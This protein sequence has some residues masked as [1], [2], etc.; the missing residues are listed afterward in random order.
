MSTDVL[1]LDL[2][3]IARLVPGYDPFATAPA[4]C[5]F[6][7]DAAE[8]AIAFFP[9]HLRHYEGLVAGEPFNLEPWQ[10]AIVA[11]IHGW[12]RRNRNGRVIRRYRECLILVARKSGKSPLAAGL[13]LHGLFCDP[14]RGQQNFLAGATKEQAGLTLFRHCKGMIEQAPELE[15][16][17][18]VFGGSAPSGQSQSIVRE[19]LGSF[20]KIV[21]GDASLGKHGKN[22][23]LVIID[24]LHEFSSR[25]LV[26]SFR[27]AMVSANKPQPLIIYT[28][29]SDFARESICNEITDYA[30]KVRDGIVD[31]PSFLPVLYMADH[32]DDWTDPAT[33]CLAGDT[34]LYARIAR[35]VTVTTIADIAK[36]PQSSQVELWDGRRWV[37]V[38]GASHTNG[39]AE[40]RIK[41]QLRSGQRISCTA[42]HEWPTQRGKLRADS[43]KVGDVIRCVQLPE[44]TSHQPQFPGNVGW[45]IGLYLAEGSKSGGTLQFS[46]HK[47]ETNERLRRLSQIAALYGGTAHAH[48][49]RRHNHNGAT[50]NVESSVL[51]AVLDFYVGG[52]IAHDKYLK[53]TVWRRD[54]AFLREV[55]KGYLE[56]D[57]GYDKHNK[58]WRLGFCRND[59]LADSIRTLAARLGAVLTLKTAF[60]VSFGE[61]HPMYR[62]EWREKP[63]EYGNGLNKGEILSVSKSS[64]RS[65]YHI[66]VDNKDGL[67][68]LASGVLTHNS[69][70][71]PNMGV[72]VSEEDLARECKIAQ[73]IPTKENEF[74][75]LHLCIRTEQ[76]ERLVTMA[77]WDA[78][79]VPV[80][81]NVTGQRCWCGLDLAA[82]GDF[83]AFVA[84]FAWQEKYVLKPIFWLP[85]AATR[86]R[87]DAMGAVFEVWERTK[88]VRF[89]PGNEVDYAAIEAD[90]AEFAQHHAVEEVAADRL[91]QGAQLCQNLY[92][93][94]GMKV[95]EHGQGFL[96]MALPTKQFL[97]AVS[98]GQLIH[99][100]DPVLRW[101]VSNLTGKQ[102]EA[103]NW[104]PDKKRSAEKIDGVVATIMGLG[105]AIANAGLSVYEEHGIREV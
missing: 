49:D 64:A 80:L 56:G 105:R 85:K 21:S 20:L 50:V 51:L 26:D 1:N 10:Q 12:K 91:F 7:A 88:A 101:M 15:S 62:G 77:A 71:N 81:P 5:F 35:G 53:P 78:C 104:K 65:F 31:E 38:L 68:A 44:T 59:R 72:S 60:V 102:D 92:E 93:R 87:R 32:D 37:R 75:R 69:K 11:N 41:F 55:A 58:R 4:D 83:V 61:R 18:R 6:D 74:K 17:C 25:D 90:I 89:T 39:K 79:R 84:V 52:H 3:R 9:E 86:K 103:G 27:T 23:N 98:G 73:E 28:T 57:G 97:E 82:V 66:G 29:T 24:E 14:E 30:I 48:N 36:K 43:L 2:H 22:P 67:F 33:W 95:V 54:N 45:V 13:A 47:K 96:S 19:S 42:H 63:S 99:D 70:A 100:G 40:Q 76:A 8:Q 16:R 94:H 34:K 46:G